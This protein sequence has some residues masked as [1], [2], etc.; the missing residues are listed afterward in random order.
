MGPLLLSARLNHL[1]SILINL[2]MLFFGC[3]I[4]YHRVFKLALHLKLQISTKLCLVDY[5]FEKRGRLFVIVRAAHYLPDLGQCQALTRGILQQK[6]RNL[7]VAEAL[8]PY[9]EVGLN[10]FD[11]FVDIQLLDILQSF[12]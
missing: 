11:I 8:R 5:F 10:E 9:F 12:G 1:R 7:D 3:M 2:W 6:G 4:A